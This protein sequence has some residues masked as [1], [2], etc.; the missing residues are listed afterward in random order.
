MK[1][2]L[3]KPFVNLL[4]GS[5]LVGCM[6]AC[7]GDEKVKRALDFA[8]DNRQELQQVIDHYQ[9]V[10]NQ[11]PLKLKAALFLIGHMPKHYSMRS[12][13]ID[14]FQTRV[15]Q[16]T[17][18]IPMATINT[19]W[20]ELSVGHVQRQEYDLHALK[21]SY[22]IRNIDQAFEVW[23]AAP[24]KK[25][26]D[27]DTFCR[28]ILPYR[29]QNEMLVDG[30]RDSLYRE[31]HPLIAGVQE[32]P[33]AFALIQNKVW[34]EVNSS[35]SLFTNIINVL[36]L[37][38]QARATCIQ[39]CV[40]LGS[41]LRSLGIP[42]AI[43]NNWGRWSNYSISGHSWVSVVTLEGVLTVF[44]KDTIARLN[45]PVD[46]STF[47]LTVA[48]E[49][50]YALHTDFKKRCAKVGRY[51]YEH[52]SISEGLD[53]GWSIALPLSD[54]FTRD[55]SQDYGLMAIAEIEVDCSARHAY[56][57]TYATG[58]D[59][60]PVAINE[61]KGGKCRF[62]N[63][64]D[65]AAYQ[66]MVYN[67]GQIIPIGH[68]FLMLNNK[69]VTLAPDLTTTRTVTLTRKYPLAPNFIN[70]CAPMR[71]GRFEASNRADFKQADVLHTI[72]KI[73]VFQNNINLADKTDSTS[74]STNKTEA[75]G[76][77]NPT[78]PK[79]YRYVRYI[80]SPEGKVPMAEVTC[81][82]GETLLTGTPF[83]EKC[84]APERCFDGDTYTLI[85]WQTNGYIFGIDFGSPK[86]LTR[87]LYYPKND[88]N[89]VVPGHEYELFYYDRKWV[90]MGR[91]KPTNFEATYDRVPANTLLLLKD[92]TTGR[93]ERVF[94]YEDG[95]QVWW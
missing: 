45:N 64:A 35:S 22:L 94:T 85:S 32:L 70:A 24:W 50:D 56:L 67:K 52:N 47:P 7:Q 91:K 28:Y 20:E 86:E 46:S 66:V 53:L 68:P 88:G 27:F 82:S 41:V 12:E 1:V 49:P 62:E 40:L 89:F 57:C 15:H 18:P 10:D 65:S 60:F 80:S 3:G 29:F 84:K 79:T 95:R 77:I 71:G 75:T 69:Q 73:P 9:K 61:V 58:R 21:A 5:I 16:A 81:W 6:V 76:R 54:P 4:L 42:V 38:H 72:E 51:T 39:R 59:W 74:G 83:C 19:W 31:Y 37:K 44:E 11:D 33:K 25:E 43:D 13:S 30:W 17:T 36:D 34:S 63:I 93:E 23:N 55:V 8:G 90:S 48:T 92:H 87:V 14:E 78:T 2:S 26:V